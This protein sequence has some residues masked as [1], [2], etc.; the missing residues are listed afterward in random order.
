[1]REARSDGATLNGFDAGKARLGVLGA[2][3][4]IPFVRA[5]RGEI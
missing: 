2:L 4:V 1:V 5:L 3:A